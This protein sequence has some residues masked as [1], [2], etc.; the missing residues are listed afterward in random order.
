MSWMTYVREPA[1]RAPKC[2]RFRFPPTRFGRRVGSAAV[3][4]AILAASAVANADDTRAPAKVDQRG[5]SKPA[6]PAT[7]RSD[8]VDT[9][10][11]V[12]VP[13]PYRWLE[14]VDS[15]ATAQWVAAQNETTHRFLDRQPARKEIEK[16][17][18]KLWNYER[19]GLP[20]KKGGRYFFTRND[21]LQNQ[22]VLY[23][24]DQLDSEPRLLL[25]P[26]KLSADGTVA[27]AGWVVSED[28][29][30]LA[31]GLAAAGSDW[32]EW[33]VLDTATGKPLA[34]H[35]KWVKFSGVSWKPDGSGFYY[36]R[37]DEPKKGEEFTGVNYFQK[38]Y[39]HK[40]GDPQSEDR[41]VYHRPDEKEWGFDG[42][43]TDDGRYLIISVWRGTEQKT[44]SSIATCRIRLRRSSSCWQDS[45][46]NT[47]SS[48]TWARS[49]GCSPIAK[50]RGGGWSRST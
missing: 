33:K 10:H 21:G 2:P 14:D 4:L 47:S 5:A 29:R 26:N 45:M 17:L 50:R 46:R 25:D 23:V 32:R 19:F 11:G 36:S 15:E 40:L 38:L 31:Y 8:H 34:D 27:L 35:L 24:A 43:V 39:F 1:S 28:G 16:R 37:Y 42:Q 13:D 48:A 30:R 49:S 41:L 12:K 3:A 6:Y 44:R 9:Y 22:S 18:T 7:R 20:E